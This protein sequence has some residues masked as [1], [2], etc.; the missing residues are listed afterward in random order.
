[1]HFGPCFLHRCPS[2]MKIVRNYTTD[3]NGCW[4]ATA[5]FGTFSNS[6]QKLSHSWRRSG[7]NE[8]ILIQVHCTWYTRVF[9]MK[10]PQK[11][12]W[13]L[14]PFFIYILAI[15]V[16]RIWGEARLC[17][18]WPIMKSM[19]PWFTVCSRHSS[20]NVFLS[21]E[22]KKWLQPAW[23]YVRKSGACGPPQYSLGREYSQPWYRLYCQIFELSQM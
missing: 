16:L 1:M 8:P 3:W 4:F 7:W 11:T 15:R 9:Q 6:P 14:I 23:N 5:L 22:M 21:D 13:K 12:M 18:M 20:T 2:T 19:N 17:T 10:T